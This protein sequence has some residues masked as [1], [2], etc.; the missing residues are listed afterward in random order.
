VLSHLLKAAAAL[1]VLFVIP[2][3]AT[4]HHSG[5]RAGEKEPSVEG[6]VAFELVP[7][8]DPVKPALTAQQVFMPPRPLETPLPAYPQSA[9]VKNAGSMTVVVRIFVEAD[10]SVEQVLDSPLGIPMPDGTQDPF[11]AAVEGAVRGWTFVPAQVRT[12]TSGEDFDGDGKP[13]Y[14]AIADQTAIRTY[15]DLRFTFEVVGGK[16]Q[17]RLD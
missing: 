10:G 8:P 15:L 5:N 12:L 2:G 6:H 3:C 9:L 17:V 13:D 16:G 11:R 7:D 1:L 4:A 14:Q